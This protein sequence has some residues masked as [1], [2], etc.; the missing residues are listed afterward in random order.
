MTHAQTSEQIAAR[1]N[2]RGAGFMVVAMLCFGI[3]DMFIK[4]LGGALPVGQLLVLLGLGGT[5]IMA[6]ACAL[7][8]QPMF[9]RALLERPVM[10]RN[11]GELLGTLGFVTALTL[12]PLATASAIL[13]TT[14][15]MVTLGAA[16]FL[17]EVVGWRRWMAIG[18]GLFGVMLVIRPGTDGF[19]WNA[20]F[21]VQGMIGLS[22]RDLA[23]RRT[24]PA[25]SG[26]QLS[27][28]AFGLIIPAG[29]ALMWV[30]GDAYVALDGAQ[31]GL[32]A[33]SAA[34]GSVSYLFI[35]SAM[36]MGDVSFVTPFRYSRMVFALAIGILVFAEIP[37]TLTIA[38]VAII[39]CSGLY[40][41][42]REQ[43]AVH[44][45]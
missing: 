30:R 39:V 20:L 8:G 10:I 17:G 40:T 23:T 2:L 19:D 43:R 36:R 14:P 24:T 45:L 33:A 37:D 42:W 28:I 27:F 38:G 15:L 9:S 11:A 5:V 35:V 26:L 29:A 3:E 34:I 32:V 25:L 41:L 44:A 6:V 12:I 21:A 31:W 1:E 16:L 4:M 18:L 22:I 13:Q 7:K